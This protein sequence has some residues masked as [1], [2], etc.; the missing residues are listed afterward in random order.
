MA[1]NNKK[2]LIV[3]KLEP[4]VCPDI[5]IEDVKIDLG[6]VPNIK[7]PDVTIKNT[8][9]R[10]E[11]VELLRGITGFVFEVMDKK[12]IKEGSR[13]KKDKETIEMLKKYDEMRKGFYK[14]INRENEGK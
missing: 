2:G 8:S 13:K 14:K 5:K 3:C 11:F 6:A 9:K 10:A 12:I 1:K 4:P 7:I